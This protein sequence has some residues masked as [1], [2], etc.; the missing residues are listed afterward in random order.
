MRAG[1]GPGGVG[2]GAV[3]SVKNRK[4]GLLRRNECLEFSRIMMCDDV[5]HQKLKRKL[6]VLS[7]Y[8]LLVASSLDYESWFGD[9]ETERSQ[10][11]N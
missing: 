2:E 5:E 8:R 4:K 11:E 10:P 6:A 1:R 3:L 9:E 7:R